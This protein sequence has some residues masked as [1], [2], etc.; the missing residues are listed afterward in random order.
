M[1]D[2]WEHVGERCWWLVPGWEKWE[3]VRFWIWMESGSGCVCQQTGRG[4]SGS[5]A[6]HGQVACRPVVPVVSPLRSPRL[7]RERAGR[8]WQV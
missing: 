3:V 1:G 2:C 4:F 8:S 7:P 6:A 5:D